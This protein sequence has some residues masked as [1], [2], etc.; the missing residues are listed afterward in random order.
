MLAKKYRLNKEIDINKVLKRGKNYFSPIFNLKIL[1]NNL[2]NSR[3]CIIIST[4]ISKKSV[5]RNRAK[6]QLSNIIYN[7][8]FNIS[9][10][11][12]FVILTKPAVTI[13]KHQELE[14]VLIS[15]FKKAKILKI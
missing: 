14:R 11:H 15:L 13:T 12:D 8:L 1:E 4:K 7:N 5:V 6:R 3:F 10:N 9:Q 2:S